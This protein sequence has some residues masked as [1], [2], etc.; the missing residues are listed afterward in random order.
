MFERAVVRVSITRTEQEITQI[1]QFPGIIV[2]LSNQTEN[3][4]VTTLKS[5][6]KFDGFYQI[7]R[8]VIF[9]KKRH[10]T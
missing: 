6:V 10:Q 3:C 4:I 5:M 9:R 2:L 7:R 1:Q 8:V